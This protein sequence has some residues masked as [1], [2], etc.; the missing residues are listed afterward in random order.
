MKYNHNV[1]M[2]LLRIASTGWNSIWLSLFLQEK[3]DITSHMK[4]K[5]H[6][7][8]AILCSIDSLKMFT[9]QA[10]FFTVGV[11]VES[12]NHCYIFVKSILV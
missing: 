2:Y 7:F 3:I 8:I 1:Q 4:S 9:S 10:L 6:S 11:F 12:V 5:P